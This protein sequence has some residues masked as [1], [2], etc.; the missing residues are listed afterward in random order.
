MKFSL[1]RRAA[2]PSSVAETTIAARDE[3]AVSLR[4]AKE[5]EE[6]VGLTRLKEN[7][8]HEMPSM[9]PTSATNPF[10]G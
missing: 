5:R 4:V 1:F 7:I 9:A 2:T 3:P 8:R 6:P 10:S